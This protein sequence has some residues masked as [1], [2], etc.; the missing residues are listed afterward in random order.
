VKILEGAKGDISITDLTSKIFRSERQ[1]NRR[2]HNIVGITP[3]HFS[4]ICK[5][6][7]VINLMQKKEY[8]SIQDLSFKGHYY[9]ASSFSHEFKKLTGLSPSQFI[10]SDDHIALKY[11]TD[12]PPQ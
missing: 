12:I 3:K 7:H 1:F 2:F 5:L 11:F 10:E 9:D 6:H 8:E 4:R